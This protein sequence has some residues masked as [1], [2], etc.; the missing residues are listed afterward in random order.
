[1]RDE[2]LV[3]ESFE[4]QIFDGLDVTGADLSGKE[5]YRCTFRGVRMAET[6]WAGT[7]LE[8]CVFER[9]DLTRLQPKK[10]ALRGVKFV[11]SKLMGIDWT[12]A[13]ANPTVEFQDCTLRYASFVGNNLR[14]T[15]FRRC[16]LAEAAFEDVSLVQAVF[17]ECDLSGARFER[18]DLSGAD[19]STAQGVFFEP[20]KNRVK[21]AR[22]PVETA[23]LMAMS[24]GMIVPG[25]TA[26]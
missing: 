5:L 1:M 6:T 22:I 13:A 2:L 25:F 24:F 21:G 7:R 9:C 3:Q 10:L 15:V 8:D 4:D 17:D 19:F 12:D 20:T 14:V 23:A 18:C 16:S 11:A 26:G